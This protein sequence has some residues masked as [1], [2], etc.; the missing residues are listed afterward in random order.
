MV[1]ISQIKAYTFSASMENQAVKLRYLSEVN[2]KIRFQINL[3]L[4]KKY[5]IS[6][7]VIKYVYRL[8]TMQTEN[9][10][11]FVNFFFYFCS[12]AGT[13]IIIFTVFFN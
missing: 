6:L 1:V 8:K 12:L 2:K 13:G 10:H 9:I 11:R 3:I 7:N 4:I 5:F